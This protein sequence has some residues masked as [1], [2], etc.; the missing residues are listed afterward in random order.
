LTSLTIL[1]IVE[2]RRVLQDVSMRPC[3][4]HVCA[5]LSGRVWGRLVTGL[6]VGNMILL[7]LDHKGTGAE[8]DLRVLSVIRPLHLEC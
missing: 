2:A 7:L 4:V 3:S 1:C 8:N 5:C 6:R